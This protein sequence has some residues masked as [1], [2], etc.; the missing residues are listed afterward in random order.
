MKRKNTPKHSLANISAPDRSSSCF[1]APH[2]GPIAMVTD[3]AKLVKVTQGGAPSSLVRVYTSAGASIAQFSL[4]RTV[5]RCVRRAAAHVL[6]G[7]TILILFLLLCFACSLCSL[8][9]L[10]CLLG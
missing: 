6:L 3:D 1:A 8:A 2:G 10:A 4:K 7:E 5:G 9:L